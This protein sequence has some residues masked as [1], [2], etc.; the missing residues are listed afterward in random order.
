MELVNICSGMLLGL[1]VGYFLARRLIRR[2]QRVRLLRAI[3]EIRGVAG[4]LVLRPC[5][6]PSCMAS[7]PNHITLN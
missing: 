4:R 1:P 5:D 2:V 6:C 7:R 3:N